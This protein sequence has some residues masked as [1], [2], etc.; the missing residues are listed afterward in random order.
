MT[1]GLTKNEN[2]GSVPGKPEQ[3]GSTLRPMI[4]AGSGTICF[5]DLTFRRFFESKKR[6]VAKDEP[7]A[8][9]KKVLQ[10]IKVKSS[11]KLEPGLIESIKKALGEKLSVEIIVEEEIDSKI[12]GGIIIEV[13][14]IV[15]DGSAASGLKKLKEH[16]LTS[17]VI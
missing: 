4:S 12:L 14:D 5:Q 16:L 6:S 7:M 2:V 3:E 9:T 11:V 8:I 13:D 17:K 15:I 1:A 10:R